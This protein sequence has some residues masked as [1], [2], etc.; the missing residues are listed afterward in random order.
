[1]GSRPTVFHVSTADELRFEDGARFSA[2]DPSAST[3]TVAPPEAFGFLGAAPAGV[4]VGGSVLE[5]LGVRS[6]GITSPRDQRTP[7]GAGR[8]AR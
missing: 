3:F 4:S 2:S 8:V 1:M 5:T 6:G 7:G